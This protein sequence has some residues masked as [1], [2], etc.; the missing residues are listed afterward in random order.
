MIC[1]ILNGVVALAAIIF[2]LTVVSVDPEINLAQK[3]VALYLQPVLWLAGTPHTFDRATFERF[4]PSVG[5]HND[6]EVTSF[7]MAFP[8]RIS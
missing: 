1:L 3:L 8:V 5:P 7:D 4:N 2:Y 6:G